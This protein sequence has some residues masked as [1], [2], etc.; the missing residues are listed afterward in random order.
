ME[1]GF[2][3]C[4]G[5]EKFFDT[6]CCEAGLWPDA[7]GVFATIRALKMYGEVA[8]GDTRL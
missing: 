4:R 7:A 3:A 5:A 6:K 2:G 1:G 8:L